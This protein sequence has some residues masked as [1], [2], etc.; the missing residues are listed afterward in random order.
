VI[1]R[2]A[3]ALSAHA[4]RSDIACRYGGEEFALLLPSAGVDEAGLVA[5]RLRGAVEASPFEVRGTSVHVTISFGVASTDCL[6]PL[7]T[8]ALISRADR[9][10]YDA[11]ESG[12]NRV[13]VYVADRP[14][15][16][17][18]LSDIYPAKPQ[19]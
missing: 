11:K 16:I 13:H 12:R 9:A 4:R 8:E 10:L 3:E 2:V 17:R 15:V 5:E 19:P 6:E 18:P 14:G 7:T 1:Q